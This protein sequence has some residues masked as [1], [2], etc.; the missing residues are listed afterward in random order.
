MRKLII[1]EGLPASGKS[2]L[3]AKLAAENDHTV[4][5]NRDSLR[6][7]IAGRGNDPNHSNELKERMLR[8]L[9]TQCIATALR[10][11]LD[12][13]VDDTNLVRRMVNE[14]HTVAKSVGDVE[15]IEVALN[16]PVE[17]CIA[18]DEKRAFPHKVGAQVITSMAKSAGILQGKSL[19]NSTKVYPAHKRSASQVQS[20]GRPAIIC[21]LDGTL[22]IISNRS[23]HD[24]SNC[25]VKDKPNVAVINCVLAMYNAGYDVLFM[26]GRDTKFRPETERFIQKHCGFFV[27]A[28]SPDR[29]HV[30]KPIKYELHMRGEL[31]QDPNVHDTR[32]DDIVKRELYD[33]F[34]QDKYDVLFALD[35][36]SQV[37]RLWRDIGIP[38]FQVADGDF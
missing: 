22:A 38:T 8:S 4:C 5:V 12:V 37:V 20:S 36:R 3:A 13:I 15:V 26:S 23:P 9:R 14:L 25:D 7:M 27:N 10:G 33:E 11:G 32:A 31:C 24:A 16:V 17:E 1:L 19:Q 35:D 34:V 28:D 18:R 21:D 30:W 6:T 2:T 29:G